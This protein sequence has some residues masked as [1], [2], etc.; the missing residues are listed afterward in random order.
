MVVPDPFLPGFALTA[1]GKNTV[2][3]LGNRHRCPYPGVIGAK[4]DNGGFLFHS[5][6]GKQGGILLEIFLQ[7]DIHITHGENIGFA[8]PVGEVSQ[9]AADGNAH[10]Q[11]NQQK[12][13]N[14]FL[15]HVF[16]S[17]LLVFTVASNEKA[18]GSYALSLPPNPRRGWVAGINQ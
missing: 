14:D 3:V 18:H 11:R 13:G 12:P 15:C 9:S 5:Y 8:L 4:I 6:A 16:S 1:E 10:R 17:F 7:I 2:Q